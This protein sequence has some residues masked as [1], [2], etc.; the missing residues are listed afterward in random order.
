MATAV[1]ERLT[2]PVKGG[3]EGWK[4][5]LKAQLQALK[6]QP[7]YLRTRWGPWSE[8]LQK[9]DLLVGWASPEARE[10]AI[11][12]PDMQKAWGGLSEVMD[13]APTSYFVRFSPPAP[14]QV[15]DSPIVEGLSFHNCTVPEEEMR[16]MVEKA[17]SIPGCNGVA[18]GYSTDAVNGGKIFVA[19]IGWESLEAS[20]A[21]DK[22]IYATAG[23]AQP[24]IHHVNF[25][26]P[27]KGFG[28]L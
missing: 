16:A 19:A 4:E 28:G 7:G 23:G 21:A 24:E 8:D 13:G 14:K 15:I 12:T 27:I 20:K 1:T 22:S 9:L 11:A 26:F 3:V 18:S 2:I 6:T 25:N 10:T 17:S 5:Q